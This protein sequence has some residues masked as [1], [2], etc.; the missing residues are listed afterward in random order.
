MDEQL[1]DK[2]GRESKALASAIY[3]MELCINR[4]QDLFLSV[5]ENKTCTLQKA[6]GKL[7]A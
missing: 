2:M 6:S 1:R 7:K 5:V 4:Y 3:S